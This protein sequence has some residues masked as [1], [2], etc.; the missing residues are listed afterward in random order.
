MKI[1]IRSLLFYTGYIFMIISLLCTKVYFL[2]NYIKLIQY[3]GIFLLLILFI[4]QNVK[5]TI[6]K[7]SLISLIIIFIFNIISY[8][9]SKDII[10]FQMFL[11][12]ATYRD[13]NFENFVKKDFV[14]KL[15]ISIFVMGLYFLGLTE[16]I[17]LYEDNGIIRYSLGFG[18]PNTLGF[19]AMILGLEL[20][21]ICRNKNK[22]IALIFCFFIIVFIDKIPYSRT[23]SVILALSI[24][25]VF[26]N[27]FSK[28]KILK[29]KVSKKIICS[30]FIILLFI[31]LFLVYLYEKQGDLGNILNEMFSG[32]LEWAQKYLTYYQ[33]NL[34]GNY[35]YIPNELT[36]LNGQYYLCV[37]NAYIYIL[38]S[39]GITTIFLF[40]ILY[41][42]LFKKLYN[43]EEY[44]LIIIILVLLTSGLMETNIFRYNFNPFLILFST[45]FWNNEISDDNNRK[46]S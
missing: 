38:L 34:F 39:F 19:L 2:K 30:S 12:I 44:M 35:V 36:L 15:V 1:K 18:H 6:N 27:D 24:F 17:K 22:N 11:L 23:S 7:K 40:T 33:I 45:L 29:F 16:N 9:Y 26:I 42:K 46:L 5:G 25:L 20:L 14:I 8:M 3:S 37:D 28:N 32:R 4:I 10:I 31:A 41:N 21:Y 13:N 43:K